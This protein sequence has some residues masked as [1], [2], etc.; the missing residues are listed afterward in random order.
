MRVN[1]ISRMSMVE[2]YRMRVLKEMQIYEEL[3]KFRLEN[4]ILYARFWVPREGEGRFRDFL[5][6][7]AQSN[8][9]VKATY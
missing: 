4:G 6:G 3:N 5:G 8:D 9:I 2:Q 1:L 7:L